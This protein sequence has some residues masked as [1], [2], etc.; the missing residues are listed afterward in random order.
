MIKTSGVGREA[1]V[2]YSACLCAV[3]SRSQPS[4]KQFRGLEFVLSDW[5]RAPE[6]IWRSGDNAGGG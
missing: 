6:P 4:V 2:H 3:N 5:K 1:T